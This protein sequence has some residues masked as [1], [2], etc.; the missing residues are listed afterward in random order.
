MLKFSSD[1]DT[2]DP[3]L[4]I[5]FITPLLY[6]PAKTVFFLRVGGETLIDHEYY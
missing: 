3:V 2:P 5:I 1:R 4:F 6:R